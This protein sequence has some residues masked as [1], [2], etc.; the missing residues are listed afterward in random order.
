[1]ASAQI[2]VQGG[3]R[4]TESYGPTATWSAASRQSSAPPWPSPAELLLASQLTF[5]SAPERAVGHPVT[6]DHGSIGM[7]TGDAATAASVAISC[8]LLMQLRKCADRA[9]GQAHVA[10]GV[11]A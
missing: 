7:G 8:S 6:T 9:H 4:Q 5:A 2:R 10:F 11:A 3:A 1:M